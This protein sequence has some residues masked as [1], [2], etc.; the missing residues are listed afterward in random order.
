MPAGTI[1]KNG[2]G[3]CIS[4]EIPDG[5]YLLSVLETPDRGVYQLMRCGAPVQG[6]QVAWVKYGS[7]VLISRNLNPDIIFGPCPDDAANLEW[8]PD[9][10]QGIYTAVRFTDSAGYRIYRTHDYSFAEDR[11]RYSGKD[12]LIKAWVFIPDPL[13]RSNIL[14]GGK[15]TDRGDSTFPELEAL[16][17]EILLEARFEND[18]IRLKNQW[19]SFAEVSPPERP[20]ADGSTDLHFRRNEPGFEEVNVFWHISELSKWWDSLGFNHYRDTVIIDVHAFYGADESAFDPLKSPP[21][22]EFGDGGVDDAEDAD[23]PV[24]EY[25]HAAM[26]GLV[27]DAYHGTERQAVE[28]GIC[29]FMAVC[30]SRRFTQY[31][32]GWVYNWDGHNEFWGG[33]NLDNSRKYPADITSQPHVDGQLFGAALYDLSLETGVDSALKILMKAMPLMVSGMNM[34][35]AANLIIQSDSLY[36]NGRNAWSLVKAFYP[37][38]LL[39]SASLQTFK[40]PSF[41][42]RNSGEFANGTGKLQIM[43]T[44]TGVIEIFDAGGKL[45]LSSKLAAGEILEINPFGYKP[46][47]YIVR[48]GGYGAKIIK[49]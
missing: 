21:T 18:S 31:Q 19:I 6:M 41:S 2:I 29:D 3:S 24:H 25:T 16:Q 39:P 28:E 12:T 23:A 9:L 10:Q 42:I 14:Y 17:S 22:I 15:Y 1:E 8:I 40:R 38:G 33:R 26:N 4:D 7:R 30:Y 34:R 32:K 13:S 43:A 47:L 49:F 5:T 35:Q 27:P 37:R 45:L 11:H 48:C 46:G 20:H 44:T 36:S